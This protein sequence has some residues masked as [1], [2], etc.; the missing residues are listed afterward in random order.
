MRWRREPKTVQLVERPDQT[1]CLCSESRQD[2]AERHGA[3]VFPSRGI[4]Q[5]ANIFQVGMCARVRAMTLAT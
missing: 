3:G 1:V 5:E 2:E 4:S